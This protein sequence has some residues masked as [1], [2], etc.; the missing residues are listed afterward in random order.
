MSGGTDNDR[1]LTEGEPLPHPQ[2]NW[3][4]VLFSERPL[5]PVKKSSTLP[6]LNGIQVC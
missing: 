2:L 3:K 6:T 5:K 4:P 1:E